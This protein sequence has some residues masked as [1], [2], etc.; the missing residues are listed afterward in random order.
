[1]LEKTITGI[2]T[3]FFLGVLGVAV[4]LGVV[5]SSFWVGALAFVGAFLAL[6]NIGALG[7]SEEID[8]TFYLL[9]IISVTAITIAAWLANLQPLWMV[10]ALMAFANLPPIFGSDYAFKQSIGAAIGSVLLTT[11]SVPLVVAL[12]GFINNLP[13]ETWA[14]SL[15]LSAVGIV[16][17][18]LMQAAAMNTKEYFICSGIGIAA[19][20][21]GVWALGFEIGWW[22]LLPC[23]AVA[24]LIGIGAISLPRWGSKVWIVGLIIAIL[25][26]LVSIGLPLMNA[27]ILPNPFTQADTPPPTQSAPE[28]TLSAVDIAATQ[29]AAAEAT[30]TQAYLAEQQQAV[31]AQTQTQQALVQAKQQTQT[32]IAAYTSTPSPTK[33]ATQVPETSATLPGDAEGPGFFS[34][35][36]TF[37]WQGIKSAWG[38]AYLVILIS[39]GQ[40]W[41]KNWGG[42]SLF[43][44]LLAGVGY[45]GGKSA[46]VLAV[47][48]DLI[49]TGP[50]TWWSYILSYSAQMTGT[51]GWGILG[52]T[53]LLTI[54]LLPALKTVNQFSQNALIA[55]K[56]QQRDGEKAAQDFISH[57]MMG[58]RNYLATYIYLLLASVFPVALW[59]ALFRLASNASGKFPF[60]IVPD[61]TVPHWRPVWH[62][63]YFVVG[64]LFLIFYLIYVGMVRK[65][66]PENPF[67]KIGIW[68]AIPVSILMTL[69]APSGVLLFLAG[70]LLLIAIVTPFM[71]SK[72]KASAYRP[73]QPRPEPPKPTP[74]NSFEDYLN[75]IQKRLDEDKASE[76]DFFNHMEPEEPE[77]PEE[78]ADANR[79]MGYLEGSDI[80]TLSSPLVGG[81]LS[82]NNRL[83]V[84]DEEEHLFWLV[85]GI[86]RD[87]Q[88]LDLTRPMALHSAI[89]NH[90]VAVGGTGIVVTITANQTFE[91]EHALDLNMPL[92]TSAVNS[93]GTLMAYVSEN[94]PGEVHGLFLAAKRDQLFLS[95]GSEK[96]TCLAFSRN[97]RYIGVGTGLGRLI[98]LDIATHQKVL[99]VPDPD[100]GPVQMIASTEDEKW[101]CVYGDGWVAGWDMQGSQKG[102]VELSTLPSSMAIAHNRNLVLVGDE[103]GYLWGYPQDLKTL[104]LSKQVQNGAVTHIFV[105]P[106]G[107]VVTVGD[108]KELRS[109]VL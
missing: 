38:F 6:V 66:Q 31:D 71:K 51:I 44:L 9:H 53:L 25:L 69:F 89:D 14:W 72:A 60:L 41:I 75:E 52:T 29:L 58:C 98:V 104:S 83:C 54:I 106:D 63:S 81:Y 2:L 70:Q 99:E 5:S 33:T 105:A 21:G 80:T 7:S 28:G 91:I 65:N 57:E 82:E 100:M 64:G 32:A 78:P 24:V 42:I 97:A 30:A 43:V 94:E 13:P 48:V 87:D 56:I 88:T 3:I 103:A 74:A 61:L 92:S 45:F 109:L 11:L 40:T 90:L 55:Q 49:T 22:W 67:S 95:L 86:R 68:A 96:V 8:F 47:C 1:M 37:L 26:A 84:L 79:T 108:G 15:A 34:A 18:G 101:I 76:T 20:L 23:L 39:L 50:A 59:V 4:A 16:T 17:S 93:Y 62:Y 102:V 85:N 12:P 27:G 35:I 36:G 46:N 19:L 10:I 107:S 77:E 73:P